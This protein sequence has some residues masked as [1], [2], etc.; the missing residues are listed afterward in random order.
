MIEPA[1]GTLLIANPHLDD[2]N[3][4]RTVVFL[5]EHSEEGSFGF[6]LN[7][8]LDYAIE[9]LVP[10]LEDFKIPVFEGGPVELNTLH[11]LHQYPDAI[12]GGKEIGEGLFWGGEFDKVIELI[13]S[14]TADLN[15]IRFFLGYS[16]W[17]GGQ[18][19]AEMEERTWIVAPAPAK[20]IFSGNE[21]EL[22]KDVLK[23]LG[24]EYELIINA[25]LDPRMN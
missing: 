11:F 7:R 16:G 2:P 6:V 3:F 9:E 8:K 20:F 21:K 4:L 17:S 14:R 25:P 23:D 15:K 10:E 18:L 12:P 13:N 24:G 1:S 22:W 5:C 19:Q